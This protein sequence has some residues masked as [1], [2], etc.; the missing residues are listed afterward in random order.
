MALSGAKF[1]SGGASGTVAVTL[2][3]LIGSRKQYR[4]INF[5]APSNTGSVTISMTST[6]GGG[7]GTL[8]SFPATTVKD[9]TIG[10]S[11]N[12]TPAGE[13]FTLDPATIFIKGGAVG[14]VVHISYIT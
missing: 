13:A 14:D 7:A 2:A 6:A 8:Y 11:L 9:W 1:N 10:P 3:S 12:N 5:S 4:W